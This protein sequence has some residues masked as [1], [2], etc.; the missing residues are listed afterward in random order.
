MN[1]E[2]TPTGGTNKK[3]KKHSISEP[4]VETGI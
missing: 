2:K 3:K 4:I 1:T